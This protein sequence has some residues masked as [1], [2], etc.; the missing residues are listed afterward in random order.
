MC[1]N[2]SASLQSSFTPTLPKPIKMDMFFSNPGLEKNNFN[3]LGLGNVGM[4]EECKEAEI[5]L[6]MRAHS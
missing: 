4:K 5:L 2:S 3:L 6:Y 1:D